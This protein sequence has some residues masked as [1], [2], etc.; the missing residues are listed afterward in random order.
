MR[1]RTAESS[2][3]RRLDRVADNRDGPGTG[4]GDVAPADPAKPVTPPPPDVA[5]AIFGTRLDLAVQ[6]VDLLAATGVERGLLGP[7][8]VPRLWDRHLLNCAVIGELIPHGARVIDV[9][10]GAGLPGIA[11]A[12]ARPDLT[13][14]LL[15][16]MA[17]RVT[18]LVEAVRGLGLAGVDVRRGRADDR[19]GWAGSAAASQPAD[20]AFYEAD[21]RAHVVTARAV[22]PLGQL[23]QWCLP[24]VDPGG[25][26]LAIKGRSAQAELDSCRAAVRLAGGRHPQIRS[27]GDGSVDPATTVVEI[28]RG[29]DRA[30]RRSAR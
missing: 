19:G 14:T 12:L 18:F 15:E 9:G 23:V 29:S 7:R 5:T 2:S 24:L 16:P 30:T 4:A 17:R 13:I 6:Y 27:C 21:P 28:V 20:R 3:Y 22:A 10:S 25:R 8:E 11:L 1:S 26:L